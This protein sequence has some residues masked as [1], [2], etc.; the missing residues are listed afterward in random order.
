M[1]QRKQSLYLALV[2]I[3]SLVMMLVDIPVSSGTFELKG[4]VVKYT[5]LLTGVKEQ[6]SEY[7]VVNQGVIISLGLTVAVSLISVLIYRKLKLQLKLVGFM[8]LLIAAV[9]FFMVNGHIK[10]VNNQVDP[11]LTNSY[12]WGVLSPI[13]LILFNVLSYR[14]I[15]KD[16][17]LLASVDRLR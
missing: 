6:N 1:I 9:I 8:F 4:E 12:E 2:M 3:I 15:K 17:E 11:V 14:G 7:G 13:L 10:M 5:V 16:I